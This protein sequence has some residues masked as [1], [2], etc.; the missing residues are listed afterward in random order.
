MEGIF[1]DESIGVQ[2]VLHVG[3]AVM[4]GKG[5][6]RWYCTET[7]GERNIMN[8]KE[9]REIGSYTSELTNKTY[10]LANQLAV[11]HAARN[12]GVGNPEA[13]EEAIQEL[14]QQGYQLEQELQMFLGWLNE[15]ESVIT[16]TGKGKL[17]SS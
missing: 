15:M 9:L 8:T 3:Q 12:S 7:L 16:K 17:R 1:G 14:S 11:L 10:L 6:N 4:K 2:L 13:C 5:A